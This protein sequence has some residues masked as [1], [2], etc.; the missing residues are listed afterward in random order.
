MSDFA[1]QTLCSAWTRTPSLKSLSIENNTVS[2]DVIADLFEAAVQPQQRAGGDEGGRPAAGEDGPEVRRGSQPPSARIRG[3]MKAGITLEF[4]EVC[5]SV[6]AHDL[7]G[8]AED[9]QTQGRVAPRAGQSGRR[10]GPWTTGHP[11]TTVSHRALYCP[12]T[13][14]AL[15]FYFSESF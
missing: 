12:V 7:Y 6:P 15:S 10:P 11:S 5:Q 8:Q 1:V 4:K 2:P 13:Y 14:Y 3:I 9:Y